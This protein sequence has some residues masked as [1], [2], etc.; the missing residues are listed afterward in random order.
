M[1]V[2]FYF[3]LL[4]SATLLFFLLNNLKAQSTTPGNALEFD[5]ADDFVELNGLASNLN[6]NGDF[7]WEAWFKTS[8]IH[9]S[10]YSNLI[11]ME[12]SLGVPR[13]RVLL[14]NTG[15][16]VDFVVDGSS[17]QI[18]MMASA[19]IVDG[20]WH[21]VAFVKDATDTENGTLY[22]YIDGKQ[23][24]SKSYSFNKIFEI[25]SER[26]LLGKT[27]FS[28]EYFLNGLID[29]VRI[30]NKASSQTD[31][32]TNM[33]GELTGSEPDLLAYYNFNESSGSLLTDIKG[34]YNGTLNNMDDADWVESYAMVVPEVLPATDPTREGF[35]ANW[36]AP[37]LEPVNSYK[38]DVSTVSDF[39]TIENTLDVDV[40]QTSKIVTGLNSNTQYYYRIRAYKDVTLG[41][42]GGYHF[43]SP[44]SVTTL[45][46][47][48]LPGNAL[49]FDG[50]NDYVETTS[51]VPFGATFTITSWIKTDGNG[52]IF[53][54]GENGVNKHTNLRTYLGVLRLEVGDG[55]VDYISANTLVND[56]KW[57]HV[58]V[59]KN[60]ADITFYV[61]GVADGTGTSSRLTS[62]SVSTIGGGY[63]NNMYQSFF[64]GQIDELSVWD[65]VLSE[66]QIRNNMYQDI[67]DPVNKANLVAYYNFDNFSGTSLAD[68]S[69]SGAIGNVNDA[70]WTESYAMVV[71]EPIEAT[72][73]SEY[74][75]TANWNAPAFG[76]VDTYKL[77]VSED[78]TFS[79]GV[80]TYDISAPE[81]SFSVSGLAS[82]TSFYYRVRA[83]KTSLGDIGT[84]YYSGSENVT[85]TA[86]TPPVM[87][88]ITVENGAET[89]LEI[90]YDEDLDM[91]SIP[92]NG[93]FSIGGTDANART[94][95][96]VAIS[97]TKVTL[98][99]SSA[100]C[101]GEAI[102]ISYT[103]GSNPIRDDVTITS[104]AAN[105]S[106]ESVTNNVIDSEAPVAD[107]ASLSEI[108]AECEVTS[109]TAPTA[110]D[111]CAG[112]ITGT[113]NATLPITVSTTI[114]WT[115][116][117]GNGN[118][119]TQEQGVVIDDVTAPVADV[120]TLEDVTADSEVTSLTAP[121]ATDNCAGTINGTHDATL[122][123]TEQGT[124]GVIWTYDDGNGNTSTQTQNIV[125]D[126]STS[127]VS[128]QKSSLL[129]I[130]PNPAQAI[131]TL[132]IDCNILSYK[133]VNLTGSVLIQSDNV[134][135]REIKINISDI[136]EG[137]YVLVVKDNKGKVTSSVLIK[138]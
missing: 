80:T 64:P 88:S 91:T 120:T 66:T 122:P 46:P 73:I 77:D 31:I 94:I 57:H 123:I 47:L 119:T 29:E 49:E 110:I 106:A 27:D 78:N 90:V 26:I 83:I 38:L 55:Q 10:G 95:T 113:Q 19:N 68:L 20:K 41:D 104:N 127:I 11:G 52:A 137:S 32:Q 62:P 1:N 59:V 118:K 4:L 96:N 108:S 56:G 129:N 74:E 14:T 133:I 48:E 23:L 121:T 3:K 111:N 70:T 16:Y 69:S 138:Q 33:Y 58:A 22:L 9:S 76:T 114:T 15:I 105:L 100:L 60:N 85:T 13:S 2:K 71:P 112:V 63:I 131:V 82:E 132:S 103:A 6:W 84:W 125:L 35:T 89:Q 30:W 128:M 102:T 75:F 53:C 101:M 40:A 109:L 42:V 12:P 130:Y 93:D 34:R 36:N 87:Q 24:A 51:M 43:S 18:G 136:P 81:T 65:I 72:G 97:G 124:T 79:T 50:T 28:G 86:A 107:V 7:T 39:T 117:D 99:L 8:A 67:S 61:D 92:A 98:T 134:N 25:S 44:V 17:N 126:L 115:Y 116:D 37:L 135:Q 54:W 45:E 21:H 5:G